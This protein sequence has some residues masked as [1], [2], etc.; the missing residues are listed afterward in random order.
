HKMGN[1]SNIVNPAAFAAETGTS[2]SNLYININGQGTGTLTGANVAPTLVKTDR[3]LGFGEHATRAVNSAAENDLFSAGEIDASWVYIEVMRTP[4]A[5][6]LQ[7]C[8]YLGTN[9]SSINV[10]R[11]DMINSTLSVTESINFT[12]CIITRLEASAVSLE[13]NK[14]DTLKAWFR[15]LQRNDTLYTYAQGGQL[16]G[17]VVSFIN[18]RG[19]NYSSSNSPTQ[20]A[21]PAAGA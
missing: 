18:F 19:L 12:N 9:V 20:A 4:A 11:A 15:F 2:S 3:L 16:K 6:Y 14:L 1:Q 21:T 8:F 17:Q 10:F 5:M 13:G 7:N